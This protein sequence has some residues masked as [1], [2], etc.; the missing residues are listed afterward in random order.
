MGLVLATSIMPN[1]WLV[2]GLLGILFG[3]DT[4]KSYAS[5]PHIPPRNIGQSLVIASG[6]KLA[7]LYLKIHD[8]FQTFFFMYKT[9][10]LSYEYYQRYAE[11]DKRFEIQSKIDAW[12]ARFVEGKIAFDRWEKEH[13]VGRK[14]LAAVRTAWLVEERSLKKRRMGFLKR[15]ELRSSR[16]RLVQFVYD[17]TFT[18][19]KMLGRLRTKILG[20]PDGASSRIVDFFRGLFQSDGMR[21]NNFSSR[22]KGIIVAVIT[23]NLI[24]AL[25]T[26]SPS[27]L[28][29]LAVGVGF[30]WPSWGSELAERSRIFLEETSIRGSGS[31]KRRISSSELSKK[32]VVVDKSKYHYYRTTDGKKRYYRVGKPWSFTPRPFREEPKSSNFFWPWARPKT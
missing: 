13:E 30:V 14:V 23:V 16:Y 31:E 6:R 9:G 8:A 19:G 22:I 11:L 27:F 17:V 7:K 3:Y 5:E 15:N 18:M 25:F 29:L 24:G 1:L 20:G 2:G 4:G 12:N 28:V 21:F 10:Q 26:M 32:G